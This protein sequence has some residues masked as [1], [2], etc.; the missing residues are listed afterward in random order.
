MEGLGS[1]ELLNFR[2]LLLHK[3][4]LQIAFRGWVSTLL[5]FSPHEAQSWGYAS[6]KYHEFQL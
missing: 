5:L 1:E 4:S 3:S 2:A 6:R